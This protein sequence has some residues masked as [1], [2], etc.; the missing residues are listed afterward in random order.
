MRAINVWAWHEQIIRPGRFHRSPICVD[1]GASS[2]MPVGGGHYVRDANWH[3]GIRFSSLSNLADQLESATLPDYIRRGERTLQ[4]GEVQRL[5]IDCHGR[6]GA[7][8]PNGTYSVEVTARN[9]DS[10]APAL[11][12]IGLMTASRN[13]AALIPDPSD[14][15]NSS[16]QRSQQNAST[17]ILVSC[18]TG[19]GEG[20]TDLLEQLSYRWPNRKVVGFSTTVVIPNLHTREESPGVNCV[21]PLVLDSGQHGMH[22]SESDAWMQAFRIRHTRNP[23]RLPFADALAENAKIARNGHL[24][25][26]PANEPRHHT[27][28]GSQFTGPPRGNTARPTRSA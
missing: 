23:Q 27:A 2:P 28:L 19:A 4:R 7:F 12:R 1:G 13:H 11:R 15:I 18:N 14:P 22:I 17:I 8:Y 3:F 20:G 6:D 21:P 25:A 26:W 24:I 9:L 5:A 10:F 16:M